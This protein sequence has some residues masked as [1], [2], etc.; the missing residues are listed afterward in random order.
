MEFSLCNKM[1]GNLSGVGLAR[2]VKRVQFLDKLPQLS[3][4]AYLA[5]YVAFSPKFIAVYQIYTT[6]DNSWCTSEA[7]QF[8]IE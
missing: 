3:F 6:L 4:L 7:Q 1:T 2:D 5:G 8:F